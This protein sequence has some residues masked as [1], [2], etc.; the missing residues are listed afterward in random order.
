[1]KQTKSLL[2]IIAGIFAVAFVM[3]SCKTEISIPTHTVT[4]SSVDYGTAPEAITV[5]ENSILSE[6][7]LPTLY[8]ENAVFE[9]WY[10]GETK[11][12]PGEYQVKGNVTLTAHWVF[13][14]TYTSEHGTVPDA[15]TVEKNTVLSET[16]LPI[17]S[18]GTLV[19]KGWYDG[20]TRAVPGEYE[21]TRNVTLTAHWAENATVSYS[22][23]NG[24]VP[25]SFDAEL[26]QTL[27]SANLTP[28]TCS[29]YIF[30]GW[31]Y[32]KDANNNGTGTQAQAGDAIDADVYL[33][34]KWETRTVSYHSK[35]GTAPE[36]FDRELNNTLTTADFNS[37]SCSPYTFEGWYYS[38]DGDDN[39]TGTQAQA[40]DSIT[41]NTDLYAK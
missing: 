24:T 41:D 17:R 35:F 15:I 36:S 32:G 6:D 22:S 7:K 23:K 31:Y 38:K 21:V 33:Y 19:F 3:A 29:P 28:V 18:Y 9:G 16:Q 30:L 39:G 25:E 11:A 4:Y 26:H 27:T 14:V 2:G 5:E 40:G 34:A 20:E 13:S 10:D 12:V 1:M 8:A 37:I